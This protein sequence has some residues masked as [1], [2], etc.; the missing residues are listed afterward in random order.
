MAVRAGLP[1]PLP[2]AASSLADGAS[3]RIC[4]GCFGLLL[5]LPDAGP[6]GCGEV[7]ACGP[8][9]GTRRENRTSV[10]KDFPGPSASPQC[11]G[12]FVGLVPEWTLFVSSR[13]PMQ[14]P[15]IDAA[16]HVH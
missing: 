12:A 1:T 13:L 14:H 8:A 10:V 2:I 3:T 16:W 9:S 11:N 6:R 4:T 7:R 15:P 5:R